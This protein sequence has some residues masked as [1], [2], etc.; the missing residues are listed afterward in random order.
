MKISTRARWSRARATKTRLPER[1]GGGTSV[2][3]KPGGDYMPGEWVQVKQYLGVPPS[4]EALY[5]SDKSEL[6]PL[7]RDDKKVSSRTRAFHQSF[8][9]AIGRD[10]IALGIYSTM[11][12]ASLLTATGV[13]MVP[14]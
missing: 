11:W 1:G 3:K 5:K 13:G 2:L 14:C 9:I 8:P 7:I 4:W 10:F 12:I 6:L